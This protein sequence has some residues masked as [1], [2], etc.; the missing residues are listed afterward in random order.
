M[1]L[2]QENTVM[3]TPMISVGMPVYNAGK[4]L[5]LALRSMVAQTFKDWELILIDDGSGDH[6]VES[7][8][9]ILKDPRIRVISD[10]RNLGLAA[11]LNQ[12]VQEARGLYF[13]R[14]DQDDISY[15]HRFERQ[16]E[17]LERNLDWD[18]LGTRYLT[19]DMGGQPIGVSPLVVR[20]EEI[21]SAPWRGFY[22]GHPTWMGRKDWFIRN[23]YA[24]PGPYFCED[25]ELLLRTYQHSIFASSPEVHLAYR[26]RDRINLLK[27]IKTRFT[28]LNIRNLVFLRRKKYINLLL[29]NLNF[30]AGVL[31]DSFSQIPILEKRIEFFSAKIGDVPVHELER[32]LTVLKD[33]D[34]IDLT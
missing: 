20:H 4:Y 15:P 17:S 30:L 28:M 8:L 25:Q 16:L 26:V 14:M 22:L 24:Q 3:S 23:P 1:E 33:I 7:N 18:L 10:G 27:S 32:F 6:S 31:Y 29:N 13:A 19:I 34:G 9:D 12:S 2:G 11:R 5:R 21:V